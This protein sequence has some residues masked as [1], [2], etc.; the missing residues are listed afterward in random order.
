MDKVEKTKGSRLTAFL[1]YCY[2]NADKLLHA[3]G[4]Y[5]FQ[6]CGHV[7]LGRRFLFPVMAVTAALSLLKEIIDKYFM[8]SGF[9]VKDLVADAVG[10]AG[11]FLTALLGG[12]V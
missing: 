1:E 7:V 10:M 3:L 5:S 11:A 2:K 6:L 4:A 12:L 8:T 9:D